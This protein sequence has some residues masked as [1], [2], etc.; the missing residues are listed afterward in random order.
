[1]QL[2]IRHRTSYHYREAGPPLALI[3]T[4]GLRFPI[5]AIGSVALFILA[6]RVAMVVFGGPPA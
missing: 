3:N 2:T 6:I 5:F 4:A 1:M